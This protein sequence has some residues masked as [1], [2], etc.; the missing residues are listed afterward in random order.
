MGEMSL[1]LAET[2]I[3]RG[4][5]KAQQLGIQISI[6]VVNDAGE[7]IAFARMK[8]RRGGFNERK[9]IAKA[10]TAA[11]YRKDTK[12]VMEEFAARPGNYFIIGM[13]AIYPDDFW[14]GPGGVPIFV[15]GE[16][17]GAVGVS[18]SSPENDHECAV[19]AAK[20][21]EPE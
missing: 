17:V 6:A 2:C 11:A 19:E 12:A 18:G 1:E 10:K 13:S 9:T 4:R 20:G 5:I 3:R 21:T 16:Q 7:L 14:A 8:Q 15:A